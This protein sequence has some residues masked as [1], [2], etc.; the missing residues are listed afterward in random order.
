MDESERVKIE[1]EIREKAIRRVYGR[2]AFGWHAVV[3]VMCNAAMVSINFA[4]NP[5]TLWFVWPLAGWG[6]GLL[7]HGFAIFLGQGMT[8]R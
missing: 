4:Y 2:V 3:F 6:A 8:D 7:L 5:D 1:R